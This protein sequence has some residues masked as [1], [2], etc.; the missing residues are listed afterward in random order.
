M[1]TPTEDYSRTTHRTPSKLPKGLDAAVHSLIGY[2]RRRSQLLSGLAH[3]AEKIE[4]QADATKELTDHK[5][6]LHLRDLRDK[7][8]RNGHDRDS[9]VLPALAAIREV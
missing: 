3:D 1:I 2:Y 5:L 4:A 8:R 7:I 9:I 6:R